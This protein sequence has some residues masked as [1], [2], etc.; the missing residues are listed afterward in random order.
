VSAEQIARTLG[1]ARREG[2][3]WR[4]R[5]PLADEHNNSDADPS[6]TI[7][8]R[9]G[10]LLVRCHSRHAKERDRVIDALKAQRL[11]PAGK[12][13]NVRAASKPSETDEDTEIVSRVPS[14]SPDPNI[15]AKFFANKFGVIDDGSSYR[16]DYRNAAGELLFCVYR[17]EPPGGGKLSTG[18]D[19]EIRP[20]SL[21]HHRTSGKL[22]WRSKWPPAPLPLYGLERLAQHPNLSVLLLEGEKKTDAAA[23]LL[24]KYYVPVS[25]SSGAKAIG[26]VD[27]NPLLGRR[28]VAWPDHDRDGF[29]T[30]AKAARTIESLQIQKG[31]ITE[32]VQIVKPD[33]A[34]PIKHDIGDLID[35]GWGAKRLLDFVATK[36]TG[37]DDFEILARE[38]FGETSAT[39]GEKPKEVQAERE[40]LAP[41]APDPWPDPVDGLALLD[42]LHKFIARFIILGKH[43]VVAL[44][45][46][47]VFSYLLDIAET[48]PRLAI[49]SATKRCGKTLLLDLLIW[50]IYRPISSSNLSPAAV[51]RTID[52]ERCSLL[53][54]EADAMPRKSDRTE[55]IRGLLNSGHTRTSAYAIRNVRSGKDDWTPKKFSTWAAI[56]VAAI[57]KLPDTW[58]DRS[59]AIPM[60]R[61]P[62]HV[63]VERLIRRNKAARA[64][65]VELT[66]KIAR[67][68]A[69]HKEALAEAEPTLPD[70]LD[71]RAADNWELL[72]AIADAAGGVWPEMARNAAVELSGGRVETGSVGEQLILRIEAL[73]EE[74]GNP[75][76]ITSV[77]IC[78]FLATIEGDPWA[79][80]GSKEKP[81]SPSQLARLLKPFGVTPTTVRTEGDRAKGYKF[82]DFKEVFLVYPLPINPLSNRDTVTTVG[83]AGESGDFQAVTQVSTS[84]FKNGSKPNVEKECHG[85]TA[86][87]AEIEGDRDLDAIR[88]AGIDGKEVF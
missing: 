69:D 81:I 20:L 55:E 35:E 63:N 47:I 76:K 65:A 54:D 84:R 66:R 56:A 58:A 50:L 34:W 51:F 10:K 13:A 64:E 79:E 40:S 80:Y 43:A 27:L 2:D 1:N 37:I 46:W 78:Q 41:P 60:R 77:E 82:E 3:G 45:L 87:N 42:A 25:I 28:V 59:I 16:F 12:G 9:D 85:V 14:N 86:Q 38:R 68:A 29:D 75:D 8:E 7:V 70:S 18:K 72:F 15:T 57:G 53:L 5:C 61:K 36:C 71:D 26:K 24:A 31:A 49:T 23:E 74:K 30:M 22:Q 21:W 39:T 6:L 67:W 62:R 73:F 48:S 83:A 52:L 19:K 33:P 17:F 88:E 32:S 11:W 44:T 4:C